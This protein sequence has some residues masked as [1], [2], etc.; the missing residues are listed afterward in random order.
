MAERFTLAPISR[1]L[2][3]EGQARGDEVRGLVVAVGWWEE[4]VEPKGRRSGAA[5]RP[6]P[7]LHYLVTDESKPAP[8]WVEGRQ[9]TSQQWFPLGHSGT[10][11]AGG[12]GG[13]G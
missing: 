3:V 9:L 2:F 11:A 8:V 1:T 7:D 6:M 12:A 10:P 4:D 13:Q 5:A